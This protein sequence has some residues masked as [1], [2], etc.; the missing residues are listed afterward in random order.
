[1]AARGLCSS[2]HSAAGILLDSTSAA[3]QRM[4]PTIS[5]AARVWSCGQPDQC[6]S[7]RELAKS[8]RVRWWPRRA[9]QEAGVSRPSRRAT[10]SVAGQGRR[11]IG[12]G[13]AGKGDRSSRG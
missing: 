7:A 13:V 4:R 3:R 8:A 12:F 1:M 10:R 2:L 11:R 6:R 5:S 9:S